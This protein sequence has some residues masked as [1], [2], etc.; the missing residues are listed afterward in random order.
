MDLSYRI[1]ALTKSFEAFC[2]L[3]SKP[4]L[5]SEWIVCRL[6]QF[7]GHISAKLRRFHDFSF[8]RPPQIE[9]VP[10]TVASSFGLEFVEKPVNWWAF[11]WSQ[12]SSDAYRLFLIPTPF[13]PGFTVVDKLY[14]SWTFHQVASCDSAW[15]LKCFSHQWSFWPVI[16]GCGSSVFQDFG[17]CDQSTYI[18]QIGRLVAS[19]IDFA[20]DGAD[21][22]WLVDFDFWC[23]LIL[24]HSIGLSWILRDTDPNIPGCIWWSELGLVTRQ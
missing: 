17:C 11:L 10:W 23:F 19:E 20:T 8:D 22:V 1:W 5:S 21:V 7:H 14:C 15:S 4:F 9:T 18:L 3:S 24:S 2:S 13:P 12:L 16:A 6:A